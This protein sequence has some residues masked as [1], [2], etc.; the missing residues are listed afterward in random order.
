VPGLI[1]IAHIFPGV[2]RESSAAKA[3]VDAMRAALTHREW[4]VADEPF[5]DDRV[6]A[7]R[8]D[9]RLLQPEAQPHADGEVFV[10][11]DGEI[12]DDRDRVSDAALLARQYHD[13]PGFSFLRRVDGFFTAVLYDRGRNKVHLISD[14]Y[15]FR[16]LYWTTIDAQLWWGTE[17]KALCHLPGFTPRLDAA[18]PDEFLSRGYLGGDRSWLRGVQLVS[19]GSVLTWD[20][21][22]GT[23][24]TRRYWEWPEAGTLAVPH[25]RRELVD[26]WGR[27]FVEAVRK[28]CSSGRVGVLLSG[29]LDSR[30]ILAAVPEDVSPL[31]AVTFGRS[32]S[33]D[34]RIAVRAAAVRG[35]LHH[36]QELNERNWL[37]PRFEGIWWSEGQTNLIDIHGIGG[38]DERRDWFDINLSGFLGDVTMGGSYLRKDEDEIE[39]ISNRGRR[40]IAMGLKMQTSYFENRLPFFDNDLLEFTLSIPERLR[41]R[42]HVYADMLLRKFPSFFRTIPWQDTGVPITWPLRAANLYRRGQGVMRRL[43]LGSGRRSYGDYDEWL[44]REPARSVVGSILTETSPLYAEFVP[45]EKVVGAWNRLM[46]GAAEGRTVGLYATF[47]IWLQQLFNARHRTAPPTDITT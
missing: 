42:E 12:Y 46:S 17:L 14:R 40:F 23:R 36:V 13:D 30:A 7:T 24:S 37:A 31:H 8:V 26:E 18:A 15:G 11:I 4:L 21:S 29:G 20:L 35:A 45:R 32:E 3:A 9:T 28:R 5:C 43:G 27:L 10:W 22:D 25:D 6:C 34:V 19:Q 33:T 2:D 41:A 38:Y 39:G 1:G 44:R 47:E 16:H